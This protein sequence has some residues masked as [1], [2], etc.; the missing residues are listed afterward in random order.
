L[1][2]DANGQQ[3][4]LRLE[5]LKPSK[6]M[7][8]IESDILLRVKKRWKMKREKEK[9]SIFFHSIQNRKEIGTC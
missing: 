5:A 8:Q 6:Q 9:K 3:M 4:G 7:E 1:E 2:Q